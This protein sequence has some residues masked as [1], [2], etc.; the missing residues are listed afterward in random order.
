W[1]WLFF[2][3]MFTFNIKCRSIPISVKSE[4][5]NCAYTD[6]STGRTYFDLQFSFCFIPL[7]KDSTNYKVMLGDQDDQNIFAGYARIS[8]D[9][10][11][12]I[13]KD[14]YEMQN[15]TYQTLIDFDS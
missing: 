2:I 4:R 13:S 6:S 15:F 11:E 7:Q 8:G 14:D 9:K 1:K 3:M 10:I 5:C 12:I